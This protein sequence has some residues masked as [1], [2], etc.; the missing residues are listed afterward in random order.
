MAALAGTTLVRPATKLD[1]MWKLN[2]VAYQ[3]LQPFGA[4]AGTLFLVLS[5][6][7]LLAAIGWFRRRRWGWAMAIAII[8]TQ[9]IGDLINALRGDLVR[10][11]IGFAI[12]AGLL[13]YL[14]S[15]RMRAAF[16]SGGAPHSS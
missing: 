11:A 12:A 13:L 6:A 8:A 3:Q 5:A 9:V 7:L 4:R 10:G 1:R 14:V 15:P 16:N 2:P